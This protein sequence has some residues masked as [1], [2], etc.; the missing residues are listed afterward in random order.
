MSVRGFAPAFTHIELL[1]VV[2]IIA[3]L[4]AIAVP[5]FL[6]AQTRAKVSRVKADERTY[7]MA[8]EVYAVDNNGYPAVSEI[9]A[10]VPIDGP[11]FDRA[12]LALSTPIAYL[13]DGWLPDPFGNARFLRSS[14]EAHY[15]YVNFTRQ[16]PLMNYLMTANA[17]PRASELG[18]LAWSIASAGP[19]RLYQWQICREDDG[20]SFG[21]C[22]AQLV[23]NNLDGT[24]IYDPTN[25][26]ISSGEI[27]RT[28]KGI[29]DSAQR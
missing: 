18:V 28:S 1:I 5:N 6:E 17:I 3:I 7:A 29:Q 26:T 4:A 23:G 2:G 14:G 19:D 10:I 20:L 25:G 12:L 8:F 22:M 27:R 15:F 9:F 11:A 21:Q 24:N 16:N 13:E